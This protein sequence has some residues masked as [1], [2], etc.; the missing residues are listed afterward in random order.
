LEGHGA[1]ERGGDVGKLTKRPRIALGGQEEGIWMRPPEWMYLPHLGCGGGDDLREPRDDDQHGIRD[2]AERAYPGA[3]RD[4]E[5]PTATVETPPAYAPNDASCAAARLAATALIRGRD[6]A[7]G[8]EEARRGCEGTTGNGLDGIRGRDR[9]PGRARRE[10]AEGLA[11]Q[12]DEGKLDKPASHEEVANANRMTGM[13]WYFADLA[14]TAAKRKRVHGD[15]QRPSATERM[16]ALRQRLA[17]RLAAA[18]PTSGASV[19]RGA[20]DADEEEERPSMTSAAAAA[21]RDVA[22][23]GIELR[24]GDTR[25]EPRG[26]L[27]PCPSPPESSA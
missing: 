18:E 2:S 22:W 15:A 25:R 9:A 5:L 1:E 23:H 17:A 8:S 26:E 6:L 24:D 4:A 10:V 14:E 12:R 20:E 19:I 27:R 16:Q 13:A 11:G 3:A 7:L 21:A